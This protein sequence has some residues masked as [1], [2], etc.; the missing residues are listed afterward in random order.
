MD[1]LHL[2]ATVSAM[3]SG[4]PFARFAALG[5]APLALLLLWKVF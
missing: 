5:H 4:I 3:K 2:L 1:H